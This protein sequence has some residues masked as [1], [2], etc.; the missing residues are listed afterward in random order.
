MVKL[1]P[2]ELCKHENPDKNN[3]CEKCGIDLSQ[4]KMEVKGRDELFRLFKSIDP[5]KTFTEEQKKMFE[6]LSR[7]DFDWAIEKNVGKIY[8]MLINAYADNLKKIN[9]LE[10]NA[11]EAK[12]TDLEKEKL[13]VLKEISKNLNSKGRKQYMIEYPKSGLYSIFLDR[14]KELKPNSSGT[15]RFPVVFEKLCASFQITKKQCW[16]ILFMFRDFG[17]IEIIKGQGIKVSS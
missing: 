3:Y 14:L 1:C 13:E 9:E 10:S 7:K 4:D 15:I 12:I 2:S 6:I 8:M 17:L 16:D 5:P 11:K